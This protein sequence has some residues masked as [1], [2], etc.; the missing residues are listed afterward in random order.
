[1][2]PMMQ[3]PGEKM[4]F[5]WK[6]LDTYVLRQILDGMSGVRNCCTDGQFIFPSCWYTWDYEDQYY[7][8]DSNEST[9]GV[10]VLCY[11]DNFEIS[12]LGDERVE[13]SLLESVDLSALVAEYYNRPDWR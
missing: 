1:M 2:K 7:E 9:T 11:R 6:A 3:K 12:A 4:V 8:D 13:R 5:D 10:R